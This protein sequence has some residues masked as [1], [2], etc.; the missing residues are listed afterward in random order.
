MHEAAQ[1]LQGIA[2]LA[3]VMDQKAK[4]FFETAIQNI[5]EFGDTDI[6]P[7]PIENHIL[8]DK[9]NDVAALLRRA[10]S[11]FKKCFVQYPPS[12]IR[13][14]SPVGVTGY[15]LATQQDPFWNAFLLGSTLA[16]SKQ[17]EAARISTKTPMI[18][19][20]RLL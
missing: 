15:R 11:F 7:F 9:K 20:Y 19:S 17:I 8:F 3:N 13:T 5:V 10:R 18:F 14:L 1:K 12:H 2:G 16:L 4:L 6:F